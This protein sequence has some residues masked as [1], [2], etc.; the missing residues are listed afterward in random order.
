VS[1]GFAVSAA[2]RSRRDRAAD[3]GKTPA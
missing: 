3:E 1:A 2:T